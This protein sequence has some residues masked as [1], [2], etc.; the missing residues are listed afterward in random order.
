M[1]TITFWQT[2]MPQPS[3]T[4]KFLRVICENGKYSYFEQLSLFVCVLLG[5]DPGPC[6]RK[7]STLP[8]SYLFN[9]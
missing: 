5:L 7:A 2:T 4:K 9:E 6:T 3:S 8:L 1:S